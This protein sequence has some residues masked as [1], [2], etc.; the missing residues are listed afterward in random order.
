MIPVW[1][2][3]LLHYVSLVAAAVALCLVAWHYLGR[4]RKG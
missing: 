2:L 1:L 4:S 3:S